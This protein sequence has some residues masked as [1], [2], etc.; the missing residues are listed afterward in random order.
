MPLRLG[1]AMFLTAVLSMASATSALAMLTAPARYQA[2]ECSAT[3]RPP[4][5]CSRSSGVSS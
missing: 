4:R 2:I 1:I 5:I 3:S